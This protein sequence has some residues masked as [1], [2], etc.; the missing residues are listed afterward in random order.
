MW[1]SSFFSFLKKYIFLDE[2]L[3]DLHKS[4]EFSQF[5]VS[6]KSSPYPFVSSFISLSHFPHA[7]SVVF[8][9]DSHFFVSSLLKKH[10]YNFMTTNKKENHVKARNRLEE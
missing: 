2:S 1:S 4:I 7:L 10:I 3:I 8:V 6:D 5:H 9:H